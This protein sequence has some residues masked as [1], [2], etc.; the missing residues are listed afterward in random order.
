MARACL[1]ECFGL[2][3]LGLALGLA[4]A[5]SGLRADGHVLTRGD[6]TDR[7]R[8]SERGRLQRA[9][10]LVAWGLSSVA[11]GPHLL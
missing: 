5:L 11:P 10:G 8:E 9:V 1:L 7:R 6:L 3:A 4:L 2:L